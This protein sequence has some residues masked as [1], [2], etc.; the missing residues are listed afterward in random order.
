MFGKV[1]TIL[2]VFTFAFAILIASVF[3]TA[4]VRYAFGQ[5][6]SPTP[7][8]EIG[9]IDYEFAY[10]G[11]ILPDHPFWSLKVVRDKLWLAITSNPL[12][13][14]EIQ[15]LFA[16][17]RLK[18]ASILFMEGKP[19]LAVSTL[20]KAEKYLE[21]AVKQERVAKGRGIETAEFLEKI[22]KAS[23]KHR[24]EIEEQISMAPEDAKPMINEALNYPKRLFEEIK[25][26]ISQTGR[27]APESPFED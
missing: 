9:E 24:Q 25:I 17:K 4:N 8:P 10:P 5:S 26:S 3:R 20:T 21:Q 14:A 12:K 11:R 7:L 1:A 19:E 27:E 18:S 23:L 16:D 13:K 2:T 6:P 15:L 22:A